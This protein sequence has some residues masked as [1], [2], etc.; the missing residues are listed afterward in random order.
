MENI[1][2]WSLLKAVNASSTRRDCKREVRDGRERDEACLL[3][4]AL[5][6]FS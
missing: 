4:R 3:E 6:E 1:K 2:V 5:I